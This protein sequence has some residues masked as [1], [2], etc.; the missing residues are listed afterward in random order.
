MTGALAAAS[1]VST[2]LCVG[3]LAY[4]HLEASGYSP[5]ADA[6]SAYGTGE[7]AA[8]YRAQTTCAGIAAALLAGALRHPGHVLA[9]LVVFA[10]ARL[11][12]TIAPMDT[13]LVAHWLLAVAAFGSIAAAGIRLKPAQ[14]GLPPLGWAMLACLAATVVA[15]RS[16]PLRCWFGLAERGFYVAMLAWLALV[17]ARLV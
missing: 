3:C 7:Y 5:L 8:W 10:L 6:V 1:L 11:A 17:A 16:P 14:H 2:G 9:L 12:I 4:L 13:H 15:R